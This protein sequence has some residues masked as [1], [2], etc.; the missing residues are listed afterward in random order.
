MFKIKIYL[1]FFYFFLTSSL[2]SSE[3]N[4]YSQLP[5]AEAQKI[6]DSIPE[7]ISI[8]IKQSRDWYT[9]IFEVLVEREKKQNQFANNSVL[10]KRNKQRFRATIKV[11]YKNNIICSFK[12][13]TRL[14]GDLKDHIQII[15]GNYFT[16]VDVALDNGNINGIF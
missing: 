7:N 14:S 3:N 13:R 2:Y 1:F 6:F 16:S 11:H 15:D 9:N 4:C 5:N 12:G 8:E 10:S